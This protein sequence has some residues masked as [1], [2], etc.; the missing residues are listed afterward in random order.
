M[1][2]SLTLV[3]LLLLADVSWAWWDVGHMTVTQIA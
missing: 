1:R 3:V 2:S